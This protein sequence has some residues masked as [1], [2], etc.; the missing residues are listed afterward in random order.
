M[1]KVL[2]VEDSPTQSLQI[3]L[4]LEQWEHHVTCCDD[5][6]KALLCLAEETPDIVVTDMELPQL[7]G[8][9]LVEAMKRDFPAIPA[10]LVTGKGS[11]ELAVEALRRGAAA[12]VPKHR[13]AELL[14]DTIQHVL[15]TLKSDTSFAALIDCLQENSYRFRIPNDPLLINPLTNLLTQI[16][17]GM[18]LL[19]ATEMMRLCMAFEHALLNA[20]Y[21]GNLELTRQDLP[22]TDNGILQGVEPAIAQQRKLLSPYSERFV[23][24]Q[25]DVTLEEIRLIVRDEGRGFDTSCVPAASGPESLESESGRGLIIMTNF[26][27]GIAFNTL[28]NEVTMVKRAG[29]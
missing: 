23:E 10:V 9:Q 29:A 1:S 22:A 24:V 4:M 2:L 8:L 20:I 14:S 13:L 7:N 3:R 5:G 28:G 19:G 12:Y 26:M 6:E 15:G 18:R 11:E 27:D 25:M 21:R 17:A 16:V